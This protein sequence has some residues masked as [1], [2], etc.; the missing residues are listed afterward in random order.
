MRSIKKKCSY[1]ITYSNILTLFLKRNGRFIKFEYQLRER[2]YLGE[3]SVV[4]LQALIMKEIKET[5]SQM[6]ME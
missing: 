6:K 1:I 5:N 2:S 4:F 3:K